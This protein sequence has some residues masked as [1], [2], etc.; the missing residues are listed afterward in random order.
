MFDILVDTKKKRRLVFLIFMVGMLFFTLITDLF[1]C[2][3]LKKCTSISTLYQTCLQLQTGFYSKFVVLVVSSQKNLIQA[4]TTFDWLS[5]IGLFFLVLS[6]HH[7]KSKQVLYCGLGIY[8]VRL[9]SFGLMSI[10]LLKL[11]STN[12]VGN[13][14][15]S[16]H[17][18]VL[19]LLVLTVLLLLMVLVLGIRLMKCYCDL[20]CF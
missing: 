5:F 14:V 10:Y 9:F 15:A 19:I 17:V 2:L 13:L 20:F 6:H 11:A 4:F 8:G 3:Q 18:C 16:I 1:F 12:M 7:Q